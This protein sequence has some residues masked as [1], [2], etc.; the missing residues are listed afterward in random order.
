[1]R[2]GSIVAELTGDQMNPQAV[3]A[4]AFSEQVA[5]GGST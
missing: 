4:A 1:M 3:L 5:S 2:H